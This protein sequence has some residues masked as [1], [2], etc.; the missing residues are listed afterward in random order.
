MIPTNPER[1]YELVIDSLQFS[2]KHLRT[3]SEFRDF[4]RRNFPGR[5]PGLI[6]RERLQRSSHTL[7]ESSMSAPLK[8]RVSG[9]Q[10]IA[11]RLATI[12]TSR[13]SRPSSRRYVMPGHLD[14]LIPAL[15][16]RAN[17]TTLRVDY[18]LLATFAAKPPRLLTTAYSLPPTSYCLSLRPATMLRDTIEALR[19]RSIISHLWLVI[20]SRSNLK[21]ESDEKFRHKPRAAS[22]PAIAALSVLLLALAA[23]GADS[24]GDQ[25]ANFAFAHGARMFM[26]ASLKR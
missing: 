26:P 18:S 12:E 5:C 13:F 9:Q 6:V 1:V 11:R 24:A 16:G 20:F 2:T 4:F 19:R 10:Q 22:W 23:P 7:A 15:K 25:T 14:N 17:I 21:T 8:G 3:L